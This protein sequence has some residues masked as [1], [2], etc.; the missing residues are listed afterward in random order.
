MRQLPF[1]ESYFDVVISNWAIHNI[2]IEADRQKALDEI[3]RVLKPNGM[4]VLSDIV[5]QTEYAK[6]F[7]SRLSY[8]GRTWLT[9]AHLEC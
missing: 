9:A 5:N 2:E 7:L 1:P 6:Y 8:N 3:V 4:V